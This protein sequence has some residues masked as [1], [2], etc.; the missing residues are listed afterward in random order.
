[1]TSTTTTYLNNCIFHRDT[2]QIVAFLIG[3][4]FVPKTCVLCKSYMYHI[5]VQKLLNF[6]FCWISVC[7]FFCGNKCTD[8]SKIRSTLF[9]VWD[10]CRKACKEGEDFTAVWF[11]SRLLTICVCEDE[12]WSK[13]QVRKSF[14]HSPEGQKDEREDIK[15]G[16]KIAWEVWGRPVYERDR[17][18]FA[19]LL[20]NS[21]IYILSRLYEEIE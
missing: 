18:Y 4:N 12:R 17:S 2:A 13:L 9:S 3:R 19:S 20:G 15:C 11:S 14:W 8:A 5:Y 1:M 16:P 10:Q 6:L 21:I 7:T